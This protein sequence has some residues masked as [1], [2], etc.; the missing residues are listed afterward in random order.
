[1]NVRPHLDQCNCF[2]LRRAARRV[3]RFYDGILEE[4]GLRVTQYLILAL[5]HDAPG[6]AINVMADTLDIERT[7][8]GKNLRP[9]ERE[10]LIRI[11]AS[12]SDTR[13][14]NVFLT[15]AGLDAFRIAQPLWQKAQR[16]FNQANGAK[17]ASSLRDDL[18][19]LVVP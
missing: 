14:R 17:A 9:L 5:L 2:A 4:A 19:R 11:E 10:G 15:E 1:M 16:R 3:S 7:A 8:M 18:S 6:S 12:P 13:S